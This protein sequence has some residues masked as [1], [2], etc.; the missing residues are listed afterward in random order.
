MQYN[1]NSQTVRY[2]V[3]GW[4][5]FYVLAPNQKCSHSQGCQNFPFAYGLGMSGGLI[6]RVLNRKDSS[7]WKKELGSQVQA[8]KNRL[9]SEGRGN[10]EYSVFACFSMS[11]GSSHAKS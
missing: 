9:E 4:W 3:K 1:I 8:K 7:I 2:A 11:S 6:P 5:P 10:F